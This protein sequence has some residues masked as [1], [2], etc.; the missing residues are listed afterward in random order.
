MNGLFSPLLATIRRRAVAPL[1]RGRVLDFG[2]GVGRLCDLV[3]PCAFVGIDADPQAIETAR[4]NYPHHVFH[5]LDKLPQLDGFDTI[6]AMAVIGHVDD[7][8]DLLRCF[9][10]KL[11]PLG[12]IVMTSPVREVGPV[13]KFGDR[14]G[15]FGDDLAKN[16][17][18]LPNRAGFESAART[19]G[20]RVVSFGRFM[21]GLNQ[22]VV[23]AR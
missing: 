13:H 2:C 15:I 23:L 8:P 3:E 10:S 16:P 6:V 19:A 12:T 5:Q 4:R 18:Q 9:A 22:L 21:F 14:L 17:S 1:L 11:T 7:L 20:L